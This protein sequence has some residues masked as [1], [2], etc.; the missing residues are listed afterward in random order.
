M[1]ELPVCELLK[2]SPE[3]KSC[4]FD[5]LPDDY[6]RG[7]VIFQHEGS[8]VEWSIDDGISD[9]VNDPK[10]K[11]L[12]DDYSKAFGDIEIT[13]GILQL[14]YI[15][16]KL[17]SWIKYETCH[18][19]FNEWQEWYQSGETPNHGGSIFPIIVQEDWEE[20]I[21]DGWHRFSYYV[22]KGLTDIPAIFM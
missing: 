13:F 11:V 12:I 1:R 19:D 21:W 10:V 17:N 9:W 14:D 5:S 22:D 7:W 15:I 2:K 20:Y 3:I 8:L 18:K 6:K 16:E 4:K